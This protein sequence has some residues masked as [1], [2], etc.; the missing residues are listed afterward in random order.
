MTC[1]RLEIAHA[2]ARAASLQ[3]AEGSA[4]PKRGSGY[5]PLPRTL[6]GREAS[7]KSGEEQIPCLH[8]Q[9]RTF[10]FHWTCAT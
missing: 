8:I 6:I 2:A 4:L 1:S 7:L 10:E 3:M 5:F 9:T